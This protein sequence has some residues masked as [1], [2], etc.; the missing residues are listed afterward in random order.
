MK[1][2]P[3]AIRSIVCIIF[4][5]II[6]LLSIL[7]FKSINVVK[8]SNGLVLAIKHGDEP[9]VLDFLARGADPNAHDIGEPT[10][11]Q[12]LEQYRAVLCGNRMTFRGNF[13]SSLFLAITAEHQD[14][15]IID[16]LLKYGADPDAKSDYYKHKDH[17][18]TLML[19]AA[20]DGEMSVIR[21]LARAGANVNARDEYGKTTLNLISSYADAQTVQLLLA[22]GANP[23]LRDRDGGT[24][25]LA[26]VDGWNAKV[27]RLLIEHNADRNIATKQSM[28]EVIVQA[29]LNKLLALSK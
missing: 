18:P 25:L 24:P 23:N 3:R 10:I 17:V 5:G 19:Y 4:T 22:K 29:R 1:L 14:Q 28:K 21:S 26:A 8:M 7:L 11:S 9:A 13:P 15:R 2:K 6:A 27:V 20:L 12:V 16:A